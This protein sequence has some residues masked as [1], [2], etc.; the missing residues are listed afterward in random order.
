MSNE[1][2]LMLTLASVVFF[3]AIFLLFWQ[4]FGRFLGKLF[5][6]KGVKLFFPLIVAS[7]C[8]ESYAEEL[9]SA[10]LILSYALYEV[11]YKASLLL[12]FQAGLSVVEILFLFLIASLPVWLAWFQI[13]RNPLSSIPRFSYYIGFVLWIVTVSLMIQPVIN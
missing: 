2:T 6:I 8:I 5:A 11:M 9:R 1:L 4:E 3:S 10:L 13:R 7:C 12:P